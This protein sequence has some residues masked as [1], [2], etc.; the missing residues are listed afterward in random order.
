LTEN[1]R[2]FSWITML[3]EETTLIF[4]LSNNTVVPNS[5]NIWDES[6]N[7]NTWNIS[8]NEDDTWKNPIFAE[9]LDWILSWDPNPSTPENDTYIV[10]TLPPFEST[11][12]ATLP[13]PIFEPY[14]S[15]EIESN[16]SND[17]EWIQNL[18]QKTRLNSTM[19][20]SDIESSTTDSGTESGNDLEW[21]PLAVEKKNFNPTRLRKNSSN[22][23]KKEKKP[24]VS[25]W[26]WQ[27]L[28]N[29]RNRNIIQ[30]E[31]E[32]EG[33]FRVVDQ[34]ALADLWG[35]RNGRTNGKMVCYKDLA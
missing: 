20:E 29:P 22:E 6:P 16:P 28:Q 14:D 10:Q 31:N 15:C 9:N 23:R 1:F 25:H 26:L 4:D 18:T 32:K 21:I 11:F 27:L 13:T 17:T 5:L 34:K 24:N 3:S 30:F 35:H 19:E 8:S 2:K 12:D 7:F 33:E